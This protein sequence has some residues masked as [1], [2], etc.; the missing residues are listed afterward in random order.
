MIALLVGVVLLLFAVYSV[1]PV[2]WSMQ[3]WSDVMAFLKGAIPVAALLIGLIALFVGFADI[4]DKMEAKK[5]EREAKE[6]E[7]AEAA[8]SSGGSGGQ[9]A[10]G[11]S[12]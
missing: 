4:K 6:A 12:T 9:E 10:S 8:G 2:P 3:W 11:S 7:A 5:E 1:L